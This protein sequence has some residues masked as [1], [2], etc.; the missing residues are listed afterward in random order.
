[1]NLTTFI[2]VIVVSVIAILYFLYKKEPIS[3]KK[4][5]TAPSDVDNSEPV[6]APPIKP[7]KRYKKKPLN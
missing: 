4:E 1:M 7:K 6:D 3:Y 5:N 2:L